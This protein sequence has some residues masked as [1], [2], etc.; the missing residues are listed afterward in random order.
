ML[1][2]T[3]SVIQSREKRQ[4]QVAGSENHHINANGG[5]ETRTAPRE[6]SV[7]R[8]RPAYPFPM[9]S[10]MSITWLRLAVCICCVWW[11]DRTT[12][13]CRS[14]S[15]PTLLGNICVDLPNNS[16]GEYISARSNLVRTPWTVFKTRIASGRLH[17][18]ILSNIR[19]FCML[20]RSYHLHTIKDGE[21]RR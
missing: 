2:Q 10:T 9:M 15:A 3:W 21:D 19:T 6:K 11:Q 13:S 5:L 12:A 18:L 16:R 8:C 1:V 20:R 4:L 14:C 17:W 7:L